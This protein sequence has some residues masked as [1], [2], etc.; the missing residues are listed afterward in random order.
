MPVNTTQ[1]DAIVKRFEDAGK[2]ALR[3]IKQTLSTSQRAAKTEFPR[4]IQTAYNVKTNAV[5]RKLSV[6]P[7]DTS[8][9]SYIVSADPSGITV[10]AF[11]ARQNKKGLT[12][13][14]LKSGPRRVIPGGFYPSSGNKSKV[15]FKR[16]GKAR[17]P[18]AVQLGPSAAEMLASKAVRD[19][20]VNNTKGRL[21]TD[22]ENRITRLVRR[23]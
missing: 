7:V 1:Y 22:L 9:L 11:G 18:I 17:L 3:E 14:E 8:R 19:P 15:P 12:V 13:Q 21:K 4:A 16:I 5:K 10:A 6:S 20:A 2:N 23:G